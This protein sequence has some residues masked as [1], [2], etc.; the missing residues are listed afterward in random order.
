M[1]QRWFICLLFKI[2]E[3]VQIVDT[4]YLRTFVHGDQ[5]IY[6]YYYAEIFSNRY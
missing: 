1:H 4:H 2:I 6:E 5:V 3:H